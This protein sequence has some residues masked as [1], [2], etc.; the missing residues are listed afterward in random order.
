MRKNNSL[1]VG[2]AF[3]TAMLAGAVIPVGGAQASRVYF[4]DFNSGIPGDRI[5]CGKR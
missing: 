5:Y 1:I 2:V 4:E 3:A